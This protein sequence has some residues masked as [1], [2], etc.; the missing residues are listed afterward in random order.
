[1]ASAKTVVAFR[2]KAVSRGRDELAFLPAALEVVETPPSPV[3]R[4]VAAAIALF[5]C[6]ALAWACWGEVDIIASAQG[7][8]I[9]SGNIKL[10]QPFET[11]VI[12][13]IDVKD[14]QRVKA[15]D[16]LIELDPTMNAAELG[17]LQGDLVATQLELERLRA[18][19]VENADP[20]TEF[21][22]PKGAS[23][24]QVET[25]RQFLV[26]Q[27]GEFRAKLAVL[28]RQQEQKEAER[29]TIGATIAKLE[30]TLPIVQ[31]RF[32]VRKTLYGKELGAKLQY[33]EAQQQLVEMQ[34]ELAIQ[35]S[36]YKEVTAA[37]TVLTET[38]AQTMAEYR[39]TRFGEF[40]EADRKVAGL[41][42]DLVKAEQRTKLQLLTAPV[43]GI[44]Q[45]LAVHTIGG[46]V[47]PAQTLLVLVP[48]DGK[49][50][51]EATVPNRDIG[52]V[53]AGQDAEIKI[54]TFSFTRYGIL[55]GKVL[56]V[57]QDAISRDKPQDKPNDKSK[58]TESGT[59]EPQGQEL[60]FQARISLDR[61]QMQVGAEPV[62]LTPGMA[63]TVEI[64]TGS[65][66]LMSYLLSPLLKYRQESLRER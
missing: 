31:E 25:Q 65:R 14:G 28:K 23:A 22:A 15:G 27:N 37:L 35:K 53:R 12:R 64:K 40:A 55:H 44:V 47:T 19:L 17:H 32:D 1:M 61:T 60:G 9:P 36:R 49:L 48:I 3:G 43:D 8:I 51:I 18:A 39:R 2:P 10:I 11:G 57:S 63:V 46:V 62:N 7:R 54:D 66:T 29:A 33:L 42:Q 56:S 59:S 21:R 50:E 38:N 13:S 16:T 24:A 20:L 6:L 52:F 4:A 26:S 5:F 58:G 34:Q 30:A 41:I 45:Q